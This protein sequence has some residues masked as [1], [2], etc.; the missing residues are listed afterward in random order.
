[1]EVPGLNSVHSVFYALLLE[2]FTQKGLILHL[3]TPITD[4]L[5]NYG[6]DVYEVE[7]IVERRKT[8]DDQWE[9]LVKWKGYGENE[10]SWEVGL[11]ISANTL[12]VFWKKYNILPK[13]RSKPK[14]ALK[15]RGR[16]PKRK[17]G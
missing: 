16:L 9:Y 2:P 5:R 11:N 13:C 7:E 1:V 8:Q 6:D 3:L 10:N 15:R 17:E 12:K 4:T 14:E